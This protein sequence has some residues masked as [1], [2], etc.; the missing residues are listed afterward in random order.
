MRVLVIDDSLTM[1]RIIGNILKSTKKYEVTEA[2]NGFE[3]LNLLSGIKL[4]LTD[5]NMPGMDGLSFVKEVRSRKEYSEVPIIMVTT[6]GTKET[7]LE[8]MKEG[9]NDYIVKPFTKTVLVEKIENVIKGLPD[10]D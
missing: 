2:S 8:A 6:E 9:V 7:V 10:S 3:A 1:R 4:I 5:W